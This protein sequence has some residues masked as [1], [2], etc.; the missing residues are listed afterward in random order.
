MT[1]MGTKLG[2][3]RV[4]TL[5]QTTGSMTHMEIV[6]IPKIPVMVLDTIRE[7]EAMDMRSITLMIKK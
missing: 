3:I 5:T 6:T 7:I 2:T 4:T 1:N